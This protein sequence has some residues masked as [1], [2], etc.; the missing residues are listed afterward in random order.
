[1][2][3]RV[4]LVDIRFFCSQAVASYYWIVFERSVIPHNSFMRVSPMSYL[5]IIK[6]F[7]MNVLEVGN[8]QLARNKEF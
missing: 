5:N 2:E 8:N 7:S 1:M 3:S 4:Y 6:T